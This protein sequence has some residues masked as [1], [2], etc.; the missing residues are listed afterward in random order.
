MPVVLT[1]ERAAKWL[2]V[3]GTRFSELV[4]FLSPYKVRD[5]R[6]R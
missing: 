4:P 2:D 6:P 3:K 5:P 1:E